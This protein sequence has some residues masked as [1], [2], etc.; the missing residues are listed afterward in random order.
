VGKFLGMRKEKLESYSS[1]MKRD[2]SMRTCIQETG[3][4]ILRVYIT[5]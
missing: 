3:A 1:E 2:N 4:H 5:S